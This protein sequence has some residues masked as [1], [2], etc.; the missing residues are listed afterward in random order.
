MWDLLSLS[1][2]QSIQLFIIH[3][4]F[5]HQK[6]LNNDLYLAALIKAKNICVFVGFFSGERGWLSGARVCKMGVC[7]ISSI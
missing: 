1:N 2:I 3:S 6:I 4:F 7:S 5:I